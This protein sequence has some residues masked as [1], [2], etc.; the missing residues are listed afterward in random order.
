MGV[1]GFLRTLSLVCLLGLVC[2]SV[3]AEDVDI[4]TLARIIQF[5]DNNYRQV[6]KKDNIEIV[7]Q[8]A[9]AINVPKE[10]CQSGFVPDQNNFLK[11]EEE[12]TNVK[13]KIYDP[14]LALYQGDELIAAGTLERTEGKKTYKRHSE[15]TLMNPPDK[16]PM[17][18]LLNKRK[19]G[20]V[21]FYTYNSPCVQTCIDINGNYNILKMLET[22]G[23]REE[24]KAFVFKDI[25]K[26]DT[27]KDLK[28]N[29]KAIT[30]YVPL[31]RCVSAE[32]CYK[33]E[34]ADMDKCVQ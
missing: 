15:S 14:N 25:W 13:N 7:R 29:F 22:W 28:E 9:A 32:E 24:L 31:Y 18:T 6:E 19:E 33:C 1:P 5:F 20:C 27:R 17:S 12:A 11:K 10:Q 23:K 16:S 4:N 26:F 3:E 2:R 21:V 30:K 34:G 8:Y